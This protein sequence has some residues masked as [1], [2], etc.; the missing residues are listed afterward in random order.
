MQSPGKPAKREVK[1]F[2]SMRCGVFRTLSLRWAEYFAGRSTKMIRR[3]TYLFAPEVSGTK[4][5]RLRPL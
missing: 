2:A 1:P 3:A 5:Q 4:A